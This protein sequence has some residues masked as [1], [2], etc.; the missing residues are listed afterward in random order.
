MPAMRFPAFSLAYL[1]AVLTGFFVRITGD[2]MTGQLNITIP[3]GGGNTFAVDSEGSVRAQVSRYSADASAG[4]VF[5][6]KAR[7]TIASPADINANDDVYNLA[8]QA[9]FSGFK[10]V[11]Q[12]LVTVI[13]AAPS[14]TNLESQYR[15]T[16]N[17]AAS[18]TVTEIMRLEHA[19]GLSMYGANPVVDANRVFRNRIF[20]VAT[21]PAGV[22]GMRTFVNDALAPA[23]N[24]AVVG[25][26]AVTIPVF[27]AA[28]WNVG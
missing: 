8:G 12:Q 16:L 9:Y 10:T 26:G 1:K 2:T 25:G 22:A 7:G 18:A 20:T 21:L 24:A 27:Y 15:F 6:R 11:S 4:G 3:G 28:A 19:T 17:P 5:V 23:F 14:A 13:A